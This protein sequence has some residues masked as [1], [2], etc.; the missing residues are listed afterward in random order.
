MYLVDD[1][2]H[3]VGDHN[4][5]YSRCPSYAQMAN[6]QLPQLIWL[7]SLP[8]FTEDTQEIKNEAHD[9]S[10]QPRPFMVPESAQY[11]YAAFPRQASPQPNRVQFLTSD[12]ICKSSRHIK[13]SLRLEWLLLR[14][15]WVWLVGFAFI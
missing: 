7:P 9:F 13:W 2:L 6:K 4:N 15:V 5:F 14:R 11:E 3:L 12:S 8:T 10:F 1:I